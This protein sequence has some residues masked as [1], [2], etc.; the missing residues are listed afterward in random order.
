MG[1]RGPIGVIDAF[2]HIFWYW[3]INEDQAL[4]N[5]RVLFRQKFPNLEIYQ[6]RPDFH[7][8]RTLQR[9]FMR[10]EYREYSKNLQPYNS[11]GLNRELWVYLI[12]RWGLNDAEILV[13]LN[14]RYR[15]S[16][17]FV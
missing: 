15:L 10:W 7:S 9:T 1:R 5:T 4:S 13:F 11:E 2:Q 3:Y 16:F 12:Y 6:Q 14:G 17:F 8:E